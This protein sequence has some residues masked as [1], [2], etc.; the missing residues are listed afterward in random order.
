VRTSIRLN[1]DLTTTALIDVAVAAEEAGF[2]QLWVSNDLMYRSAPVLLGALARET[3]RIHLGVGIVN[4]YSMHPAEIAMMAATMQEA[5]SGRFLLGLAAGAGDFL[6]WLGIAQDKPLTMVRESLRAIRGLMAGDKPVTIEGAGA[7]WTD[8]AWLRFAATPAP[9]Y[10]GA[11]SPRMVR[12]AGAEADGLLGLAFPPEHFATVRDEARAG[13]VAVGRDP[14]ELDTPAC[15]WVSVDDDV[16]RA[17]LALG[18]KLAY[19]GPAFSPYLLER[20]GLS[21]ADFAEVQH[22]LDTEGL[23]A[24]ARLVTPRMLA[25][26]IAGDAATVVERCRGLIALGAEHLSFGP[27]LGDDPV[28]AVQ[29]LGSAVLPHLTVQNAT[30]GQPS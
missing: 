12:L 22:A 14:A 9:V 1:N 28:A 8:D 15:F 3:S 24:A 4:P 29:L 16:R 20:A 27:P 18:E 7:G 2:D 5:S 6:S 21:V 19:Y 26:G 13:A 23:A 10:L 17:E 11:M 30:K 25:L